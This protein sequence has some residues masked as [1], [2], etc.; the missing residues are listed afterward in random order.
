MIHSMRKMVGFAAIGKTRGILTNFFLNFADRTE[1]S[2][3]AVVAEPDCLLYLVFQIVRVGCF[4]CNEGIECEL[5]AEAE[6]GDKAIEGGLAVDG[7]PDINI[8]EE[9]FLLLAGELIREEVLIV[10]KRLHIMLHPFVQSCEP[11]GRYCRSK[12]LL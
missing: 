12:T 7:C 8:L 4:R 1:K 11:A 9:T 5:R 10:G 6:A 3:P 2:G